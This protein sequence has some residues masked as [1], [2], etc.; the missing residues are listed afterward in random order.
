MAKPGW[1]DGGDVTMSEFMH[2]VR[3]HEKNLRLQFSHLDKNQDGKYLLSYKVNIFLAI[4]VIGRSL[5]SG[6]LSQITFSGRRKAN[7]G[8]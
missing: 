3:E 5:L 6:N 2:Y 8:R 1:K 7:K 4:S